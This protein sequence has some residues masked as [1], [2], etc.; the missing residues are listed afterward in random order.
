M[1]LIQL[2]WTVGRLENLNELWPAWEDW[3]VDVDEMWLPK[4]GRRSSAR[5]KE[6]TSATGVDLNEPPQMTLPEVVSTYEA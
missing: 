6:A 3:F 1:Y 2:A 4:G 5:G